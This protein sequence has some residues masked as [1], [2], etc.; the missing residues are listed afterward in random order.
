MK[1][2]RLKNSKTKIISI[3]LLVVLIFNFMAPLKSNAFFVP[4][5]KSFIVK[6][7]CTAVVLAIDDV[8]RGLGYLFTPSNFIDDGKHLFEEV[9][10]GDMSP[11]EAIQDVAFNSLLS[12]DK[13]FNGKVSLLNANIFKAQK[14]A[15]FVD[16][17][18]Q[19]LEKGTGSDL[20]GTLKM[21]VASIYVILRN[22]CAVILLCLLIYT[23]IRIL[24]ASASPYKQ[25]QW[26]K[27]LF[28]WLKAICLLLFM[29]Y[30][31]IGI[32]YISDLFVDILRKGMGRYLYCCND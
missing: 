22:I 7:I 13:I 8:N 20:A 21:S 24:F 5:L 28:D 12:P 23:G 1:L 26:K 18:W 11:V 16:G 30:I 29:H 2:E 3:L 19:Q 9:F 17:V 31:M 32:F 6:P 10:K 25:S 27:A 14:P 4:S 15:N